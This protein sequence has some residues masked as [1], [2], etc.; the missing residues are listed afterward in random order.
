MQLL[1]LPRVM[2][3]NDLSWAPPPPTNQLHVCGTYAHLPDASHPA[4]PSLRIISWRPSS[5]FLPFV[6]SFWNSSTARGWKD[7]L[8]ASRNGTNGCRAEVP[9]WE[10][11][12]LQDWFNGAILFLSQQCS[13]IARVPSNRGPAFTVT[14]AAAAEAELIRLSCCCL[15]LTCILSS[16]RSCTDFFMR[17]I[18][19]CLFLNSALK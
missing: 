1:R 16:I 10:A 15:P 7:C 19:G 8:D 12:S 14:A 11:G 6:S 3:D 2:P 17:T 4:P 5:C 18:K 13:L 9:A